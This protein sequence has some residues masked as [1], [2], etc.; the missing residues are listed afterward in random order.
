TG[1]KEDL[2]SRGAEQVVVGASAS[3]SLDSGGDK[4]SVSN[5]TVLETVPPVGEEPTQVGTPLLDNDLEMQIDSVLAMTGESTATLVS[6]GL[7]SVGT[8]G[9]EGVREERNLSESGTSHTDSIS[10]PLEKLKIV[11]P[12]KKKKN[13][14]GAQ[15]LKKRR[16]KALAQMEALKAGTPST[17][18]GVVQAGSS[19]PASASTTAAAGVTAEGRPPPIVKRVTGAQM[20]K[21]QKLRLAALSNSE[22]GTPKS[23]PIKRRRDELT[24][25]SD[26]KPQ[27]KPHRFSEAKPSYSGATSSVKMAIVHRDYPEVEVT[28]EQ[29]RLVQT[30]IMDRIDG[31]N[32][33]KP[34]FNG[35][36]LERGAVMLYCNDDATA[37]W[38][39][40]VCPNMVPWQ[41]ALLKSVP[42]GDLV[43]GFRAMFVAPE[44]LMDQ[45]PETILQK[46]EGQN[47]GLI[48]S[49]WR[50]LRTEE[51][52]RGKRVVVRMDQDSW[53]SIKA[54]GF[55]NLGFGKVTV[56]SLEKKSVWSTQWFRSRMVPNGSE[57]E[58][59]RI[60]TKRTQDHGQGYLGFSSLPDRHATHTK[61]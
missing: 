1:S 61:Y 34:S 30:S 10:D 32:T 55:I 14:S 15:R 49:K 3:L 22:A 17:A 11:P 58:W 53:S 13:I 8:A 35:I 43:R 4:I 59:F 41:G 45:A 51:V 19:D 12:K 56:T 18:G 21:R 9:K 46:V 47:S 44:V 24:P 27:N 25:N 29:F 26:D 38:V 28:N 5:P 52:P 23:T 2:E 50:V 37:G 54:K 42:A 31:Q 40:S 36:R 60:S 57:T 33:I 16:Q 20:K 7:S 39:N 6:S 48:T